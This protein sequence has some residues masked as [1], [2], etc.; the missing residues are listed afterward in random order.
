[1]MSPFWR[2]FLFYSSVTLLSLWLLVSLLLPACSGGEGGNGTDTTN[3]FSTKAEL[4]EAL[5]SDVNLSRDRTQSCAT[6]HN[7]GK[8]FIDDRLDASGL[9]SAISKGDDGV[10][11]GER[12]SPTASY[13]MFSP[14]F[15]YAKRNRFNSQQNDYEGFI[16]GQFHDGRAKNLAEQAAKPIVNAVEMNMP[17][18]A[19]VIERIQDDPKYFASFK[20]LYGDDIFDDVDKAY[21]A[22]AD[23]IGLFEQTDAFATF[24]SDYDKYLAGEM[25][26]YALSKAGAGESLFFSQ[27]FTN[28]A[29]C[30]QLKPQSNKQETFT[31]YEYHN[32][33]V[34]KN[35]AALALNGKGESF[36]D[37]GLFAN[38]DLAKAYEAALVEKIAEGSKTD[39][40]SEKGKFKVPTLRNVAVTGPYMHNG[41]FKDLKTVV[42]FYDHFL[43]GS[44]NQTNPE[45]GKSWGLPEHPSTMSLK[46]LQDGRKMTSLQVEQMV[47][48]LRSLTDSRYKHLIKENGISCN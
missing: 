31:S 39:F 24:D 23:S 30:H 28:C 3:I 9:V 36:V 46:E 43:A 47:C 26:E 29:T 6:C 1:M 38:P 37:N 44:E 11:F 13:A 14:E 7:P 19:A 18:K 33:G 45:T 17:D 10:S 2:L 42:L 34:P 22:L 32:I 16:G 15:K 25:P 5:F 48:F 21:D 41:V 35:I 8:G 40:A 20:T 27:Q 4:G 12:N